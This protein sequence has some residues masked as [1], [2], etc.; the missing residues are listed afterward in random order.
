[1]FNFKKLIVHHRCILARGQS[2]CSL[3]W[4][5]LQMGI[6]AWLM[7]R[8]AITISRTFVFIVAPIIVLLVLA[9]QYYIGWFY[10][11]HK[12]IDEITL[13]DSERNKILKDIQGEV[14]K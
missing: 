10:E 3:V 6:L 13:W 9:V 2:E 14:K 1:M 8:D 5:A 7:L 12:V 11:R 4:G